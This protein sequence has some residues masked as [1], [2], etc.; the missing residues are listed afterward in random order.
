MFPLDVKGVALMDPAGTF[1]G[2]RMLNAADNASKLP[3]TRT[4]GLGDPPLRKETLPSVFT[5]SVTVS[6]SVLNAQA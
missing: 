6:V 3:F 5:S 4:S 1:V 2:F